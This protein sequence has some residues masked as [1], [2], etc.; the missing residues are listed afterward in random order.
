MHGTYNFI[1]LIIIDSLLVNLNFFKVIHSR[2]YQ[3]IR[4]LSSRQGW[5]RHSNWKQKDKEEKGDG[6][7]AHLTLSR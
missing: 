4:L 7:T 3:V 5:T 6:K 1:T 2:S